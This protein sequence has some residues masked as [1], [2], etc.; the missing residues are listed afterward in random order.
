MSKI[1]QTNPAEGVA[2][3][4][5]KT[6]SRFPILLGIVVAITGGS[7]AAYHYAI[8]RYYVST[9][10]A[11][12]SGDL[13]RLTPQISGTVISIDADQTQFVHEGERLVQ[14]QGRDSEVALAQAEATLAQVVR[15]VS[16]LFADEQ[17]DAA[18]VR[19]QETQLRRAI[20]DLKR[21]E[22][23]TAVHGVSQETLDHDHQSLQSARAAVAQAQAVLT[24][25]RAAISGTTPEKHPRV[26][27]AEA[28]LRT[29]WLNRSRTRIIAP[30]SGYIVRRSVQLGQQVTP[31]TEL[32]ALVPVDSIWIDANFK[33]TQ[34]GKLRIGQ[35]V[36]VSADLYG[37]NVQF[38]GHVL[39][40]SVGTGS[41]LAVLPAQ[42]AT[43]N[44]VK[45]VQRLPVRIGLDSQQLAARPLFLG[46]STSVK[47]DVHNHGGAVLS[48]KPVWDARLHTQVYTGQDSGA[49]EQIARIVQDN[50]T[51]GNTRL[52]HRIS[53]QGDRS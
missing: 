36:S 29:A 42:N 39:G 16:Q 12:V 44:W 37:S 17:R 49:D 4:T 11:Y 22:S 25:T 23:L 53:A 51:L 52:A 31:G 28:A 5:T 50:L 6:A 33:E 35:P 1:E 3:S 14:L 15:E 45:I 43:G 20:D 48:T 40:L 10:D 7:A 30:V 9:D 46:L 38:N 13:V 26:L 21:D 27:G 41:A 8:G 24:A 47:V 2:P 18:T 32:L 19:L 34:L